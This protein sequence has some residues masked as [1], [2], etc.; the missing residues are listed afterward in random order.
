LN[1]NEK[2]CISKHIPIKYPYIK[3]IFSPIYLNTYLNDFNK[4]ENNNI[5]KY[6]IK[7]ITKFN[8]IKSYYPSTNASLLLSS[9]FTKKLNICEINYHKYI[10]NNILKT[11]IISLTWDLSHL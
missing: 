7:Y 9:R 1:N 3:N 6:D 2:K 8:N 10:E 5:D 4:N 11:K